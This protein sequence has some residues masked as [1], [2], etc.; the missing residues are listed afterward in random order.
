MQHRLLKLGLVGAGALAAALPLLAAQPAFADYAPTGTDVVGVGSDTVQ[1][2]LDFGAD[3]FPGTAG[4]NA[5]A[6]HK[7]VSFDATADQNVRLAYGSGGASGVPVNN[8]TTTAQGCSP[9]TGGNAATGLTFSSQ[10]TQGGLPCVLNPTITIRSGTSPTLRPNGSGAGFLA[11]AND[12]LATNNGAP[13][14]GTPELIN[15]SRSSSVQFGS[16]ASRKTSVDGVSSTG[17][18]DSV[19]LGNDALGMVVANTTN[20]V[21]LSTTQLKN[22]YTAT[23]TTV[24]A[25]G[26]TGCV[27]WTEVGGSST[28]PVLAIVPQIGSGTRNTFLDDIGGSGFHSSYTTTNCVQTGEEND[29]TAVFQTTDITNIP[30]G[31]GQTAS[32]DSIEPMSGGRLNLFVGQ[33]EST[34]GLDAQG[35]GTSHANLLGPYFLDPSCPVESEV[36]ACI[37][38]G[39]TT[40]GVAGTGGTGNNGSNQLQAIIPAVHLISTGTPSDTNALFYTSRPLFVY[41]RHAD[42]DST[43]AMQPGGVENWVRTL[44]YNPCDAAVGGTGGGQCTGPASNPTE[45]GP[46]GTPYFEYNADG[47]ALKAGVTQIELAGVTPNWAY[48]LNGA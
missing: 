16:G 15:F 26:G 10:G 33:E 38:T 43:F 7:L 27:T 20:A 14:S 25:Y 44:F 12:I 2:M 36:A 42:I 9:G 29:P 48:Q 35:V 8:G 19:E 40:N 39:D 22:I 11:L 32:K 1:N 37:P 28:D 41:F 17:V 24:N 23:T 34:T 47:S 46:G 13:N 21:P 5:S 18:V 31:T 30:L 45:Y 3:G 4:F 6:Q